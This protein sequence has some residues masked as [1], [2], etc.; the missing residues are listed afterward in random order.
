MKPSNT[1]LGQ[2]ILQ[3]LLVPGVGWTD[4]P[5]PCHCI[6][7][8]HTMVNVFVGWSTALVSRQS[9]LFLCEQT[10]DKV[11][12]ICFSQYSTKF[13]K[14]KCYTYCELEFL[15]RPRLSVTTRKIIHW[16]AIG[17]R[18]KWP[19]QRKRHLLL[20]VCL[21]EPLPPRFTLTALW[22]IHIGPFGCATIFIL[23]ANLERALL[24]GD[25]ETQ[26][27]Y[28]KLDLSDPTLVLQTPPI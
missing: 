22:K 26:E 20:L 2:P 4:L 25:Y 11:D 23:A 8:H 18:T 5:S 12:W 28:E 21:S 7:K 6:G 9:L 24:G 10:L 15:D 17:G 1:A 16:V 19:I 14:I 3:R 13:L 27:I